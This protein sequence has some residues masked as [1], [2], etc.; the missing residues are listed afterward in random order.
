MVK[1]IY[2]FL[3]K[4]KYLLFL[5]LQDKSQLFEN[6]SSSLL[7]VQFQAYHHSVILVFECLYYILKELFYESSLPQHVTTVNTK[8]D[9]YILLDIVPHVTTIEHATSIINEGFSSSPVGDYFIVSRK[10]LYDGSF[11]FHPLHSKLTIWTSPSDVV[12]L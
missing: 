8:L 1:A 10:M 12:L 5:P 2:S 4:T 9:D 3:N 6:H 7:S 11:H